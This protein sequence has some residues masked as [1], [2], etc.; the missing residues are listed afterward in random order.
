MGVRSVRISKS[1]A[2]TVLIYCILL[3]QKNTLVEVKLI[4]ELAGSEKISINNQIN[5]KSDLLEFKLFKVPFE[6]IIKLFARNAIWQ[7]ISGTYSNIILKMY[8]QFTL[9]RKDRILAREFVVLDPKSL[10]LLQEGV[11]FATE[12][13][14]IT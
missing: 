14:D 6:H 5:K 8:S 10:V 2:Y 1:E 3:I 13:A 9:A 11:T 12:L 7:A 4:I